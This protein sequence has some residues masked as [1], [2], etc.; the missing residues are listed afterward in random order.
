MKLNTILQAV[1]IT[2]ILFLSALACAADEF[3]YRLDYPD[4]PVIELADA[5]SAFDKGEA[6]FIDTRT[7]M[8]FDTIH[9]KGS[10]LLDF[11]NQK[12]LA[13]LSE[14]GKNNPGKKLIL[15]DNG[16]TCLKC[17]IA[18]QDATDE[19]MENVFAYDGGIQ[20]WAETYPGDTILLGEQ[21]IDAQKQ[22]IPYDNFLKVS[23]DFET[24]RKKAAESPNARVIDARD[25]IQRTRKIAGFEEA[26]PIPLDKLIRN[27]INK[28]YMKDNQLFI[29]DQVGR[30]VRWLM[31]YLEKQGYKDYYFLSGGATAVLMDQQ[32]R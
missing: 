6:V 30:Q 2:A 10:L 16:I 17:Y 29:F 13:D 18:V 9:V 5:K 7:Q 23:L 27:I 12:F 24:F 26:L 8:E 22:L 15:Y 14:L 31:Y 28:G 1:C 25:P 3:P 11:G 20:A 32:Y 4:V 21:I 19:G